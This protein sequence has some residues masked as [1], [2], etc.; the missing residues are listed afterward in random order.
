MTYSIILHEENHLLYA[1]HFANSAASSFSDYSWLFLSL[2]K[3]PL[4]PYF[5]SLYILL[6]FIK[7]LVL[8]LSVCIPRFNQIPLF[9]FGFPLVP[10]LS[11]KLIIIYPV[12]WNLVPFA[13]LLHIVSDSLPDIAVGFNNIS[14]SWG[15]AHL[16]DSKPLSYGCRSA[17]TI[18]NTAL[19]RVH[20]NR[21]NMC[22]VSLH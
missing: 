3:P 5:F 16:E 13:L 10:V 12:T 18:H 6:C 14:P 2:F 1:P 8:S 21:E 4:P 22:L 17:L 7:N 9:V 20:C 11:F 19:C 15:I